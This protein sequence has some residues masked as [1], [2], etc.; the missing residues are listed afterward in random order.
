MNAS[1]LYSTQEPSSEVG[2]PQV[3]AARLS[4]EVELE[5]AKKTHDL[6]A[7][8]HGL[9]KMLVELA[10]ARVGHL[11][12]QAETAKIAK[13]NAE[14]ELTRFKRT[15][16]TD[17]QKVQVAQANYVAKTAKALHAEAISK[18]SVGKAEVLVE[19][20]NEQLRKVKL[21]IATQRLTDIRKQIT[22]LP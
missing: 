15:K 1:Y 19:T 22:N 16:Q 17:E 20:A 12:A 8:E 7:A 11:E 3:K 9:A 18:A 10:N 2:V 4:L 13:E 5:L 6:E 21:G 14:D